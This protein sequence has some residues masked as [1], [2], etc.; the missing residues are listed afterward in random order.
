MLQDYKPLSIV[1]DGSCLYRA[2][3]RGLYGHE[4]H[5]ELLRLLTALEIAANKTFYDSTEDDCSQMIR[6][7][8]LDCDLYMNTLRAAC[9]TNGWADA[10]TCFALSAVLGK[11]LRSYFPPTLDG[12]YTS[13]PLNRIMCGRGVR[14]SQ[15]PAVTVMWTMMSAPTRLDQFRPNHFVVLHRKEPTPLATDLTQSPGSQHS[16]PKQCL[17]TVSSPATSPPAS[18]MTQSPASPMTSPPVS[19]VTLPPASPV[20]QAP[21]SHTASPPVSPVTVP[22]AS[23]VTQAPASHILSPPVSP[24]TS[25]STTTLCELS[26]NTSHQPAS[27]T[28]PLPEGKFLDL[29]VA[30]RTIYECTNPLKIIP[31]G[32]KE[33]CYVIIDNTRNLERRQQG[34]RAEFADDCGTWDSATGCS[35][36]YTFVVDQECH[37][38]KVYLRNG[39]YCTQHTVQKK[40]KYVPL[41]PQ[42][43][44]ASLLDVQ[45]VYSQ[46][47]ADRQYRRRIT[48]I[49]RMPDYICD[50]IPTLA[51]VEYTGTHPGA[52]PHGN[53]KQS[54]ARPYVRTQGHVMDKIAAGVKH[55][56]PRAVYLSLERDSEEQDA[57]RNL[58]QVQNKKYNEKKKEAT[59]QLDKPLTR[60]NLGCQIQQVETLLQN[61]PFVQR[62][63]Q[64]KGVVPSIVLHTDEQM[65]DLKRC[66]CSGPSG[67][68]TV[69]GF[70]KTFNLTDLH[71]T[72][73]VFKN[74]SVYR[75]GT[76]KHP[77]FI[78]P[79]FIHGTSD[80][81]T[82]GMFFDYLSRQLMD[83]SSPPVLGS[84]DE[85]AMRKAMKHAFPKS[86]Q[87][88]CVRHVQQN[89]IDYLTHKVGANS[90]SRRE[91]VRSLFGTD[92]LTDA[93]DEVTFD[94]RAETAKQVIH[95]FAPGFLPHFEARIL[96]IL[97]DNLAVHLENKHIGGTHI[98]QKWKNNDC[99]AANHNAKMAVDWQS[100]SLSEL[101]SILYNE[102][103]SQ[104]K[105]L[106]RALIGR[107]NF[108]LVPEYA[109]HQLDPEAYCSKSEEQRKC[110]F[111]KFLREGKRI[112]PRAVTSADGGLTVLS[113]A[114]GGKKPGQTK[115]KR[116]AK[117]RSI[118][119]QHMA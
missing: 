36:K 33:N 81:D 85:K 34:K 16:T 53:N 106:E 11:P 83:T 8:D 69:L 108:S 2:V 15:L 50:H 84:D 66:C 95:Q 82:Y 113:A 102:I 93:N 67:Q 45:R 92:G 114:N 9:K 88:V 71:V 73:G 110:R 22:P 13:R 4:D 52:I 27:N 57:P 70:D 18:L 78:G 97:K 91:V 3:S 35:P 55:Q 80:F 77:L 12:R 89:T 39:L 90:E 32:K 104:Y 38:T 31:M 79:I 49:T 99:E 24:V 60:G 48:Y 72:M 111:T 46:L 65:L 115:R 28:Q 109:H 87:L 37:L 98:P 54:T 51:L 107:G 26:I 1:G 112:A 30:L 64:G 74:L 61:H 62:V 76:D 117:T 21:A 19:P 43:S 86:G 42:P 44:P 7:P 40:L 101:I 75:E 47:K 116:C 96:Q 59:D 118:K 63:W 5:H 103:R 105:G 41:E 56:A 100:K 14:S 29:E 94:Q 20:T 6:D 119:K 58:R 17:S 68:T 25:P 23:P 10:I